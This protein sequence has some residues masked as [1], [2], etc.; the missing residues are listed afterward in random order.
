MLTFRVFFYYLFIYFYLFLDS[1]RLADF[2]IPWE[3]IHH[4]TDAANGLETLEVNDRNEARFRA[5]AAFLDRHEYSMT[6]TAAPVAGVSSVGDAVYSNEQQQQQDPSP[7]FRLCYE[8]GQWHL[9]PG[10]ANSLLYHL[11]NATGPLTVAGRPKTDACPTDWVSWPS[12]CL[13]APNF[14]YVIDLLG[15]SS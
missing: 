2:T 10:D 12:I 1:G 15:K 3:K 14:K 5:A 6:M 13:R 7:L 11:K 4:C 9:F 8:Q